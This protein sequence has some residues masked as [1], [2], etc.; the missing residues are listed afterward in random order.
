MNTR[1]CNIHVRLVVHTNVYLGLDSVACVHHLAFAVVVLVAAALPQLLAALPAVH[2]VAAVVLV[3]ALVV[4]VL[5][6]VALVAALFFC[7]CITQ[8]HWL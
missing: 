5:V 6:D 7:M 4:H 2:L 8:C 3:V 1:V